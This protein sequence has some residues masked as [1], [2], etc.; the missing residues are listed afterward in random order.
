MNHHIF[1]LFFYGVFAKN[2]RK[3]LGNTLSNISKDLKVS[4]GN[5]SEMENGIRFMKNSLFQK[6]LSYYSIQFDSDLHCYFEVKEML[7]ELVNCFLRLD[8]IQQKKFGNNFMIFIPIK[9]IHMLF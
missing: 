5:L 8:E 9:K 6:F 1:H 2:K 3:E 4:K 7:R